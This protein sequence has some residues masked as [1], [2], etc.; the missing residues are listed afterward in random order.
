MLNTSTKRMAKIRFKILSLISIK[1]NLTQR[2]IANS[3]DLSLG[4]T[5]KILDSLAFYGFINVIKD[6]DHSKRYLYQLTP[7][8]EEYLVK[9]GNELLGVYADEYEQAKA[10]Y[11]SLAMV[12]SKYDIHFDSSVIRR[13]IASKTLCEMIEKKGGFSLHDI[14]THIYNDCMPNGMVMS[15][16]KGRLHK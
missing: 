2:F 13:D 11:E 6:M 9:L 4:H 15:K 12:L 8:G 10:D 3:I 14:H 16:R 5:N 7:E 1:V